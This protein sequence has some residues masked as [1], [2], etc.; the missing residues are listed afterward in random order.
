MATYIRLTDYKNS[1][2]KEEGF[3]KSENRYEAKQDDFEKI[4]GSPI[5]YWVSQEMISLLEKQKVSAHGLSSPGIRTGKDSIFIRDWQEISISDIGFNASRYE[6]IIKST[7]KY[8]P[9][10]RGG[11]YRKWYGNLFDIIKIGND[12]AEIREKCHDHRLRET[13]YYFLEGITWTMISSTNVS[14]RLV[15]KGV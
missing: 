11:E 7:P 8:Y 9:I 12:A 4:P 14:F 2:S 1:D 13:Q 10:T 6:N 15:P 5:S 3:F